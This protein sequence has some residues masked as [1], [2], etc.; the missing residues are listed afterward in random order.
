MTRHI[1]SPKVY[2]LVFAVLIALTAATTQVARFDF[3]PLNVVAALT[4]AAIKATLVVLFFMHLIH[5]SHRTKVVLAAGVLWLIIL[6]SLLLSDVLTR[7][8]LP[9]PKAW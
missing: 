5:S 4:I 7:G 6:I 8:W 3:G 1:V 9:A 2:L